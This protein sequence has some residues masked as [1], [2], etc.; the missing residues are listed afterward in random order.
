MAKIFFLSLKKTF[1]LCFKGLLQRQGI[2]GCGRRIWR[3]KSTC[4]DKNSYAI[5]LFFAAHNVR[6]YPDVLIEPQGRLIPSG[7]PGAG[8]GSH[9]AGRSGSKRGTKGRF[10]KRKKLL[11]NLVSLLN[12]QHAVS[13][14]GSTG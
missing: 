4:A 1:Q 9:G 3:G 10:D 7:T 8:S 14:S 12:E 13:G 2:F 11:H 5:V 6:V